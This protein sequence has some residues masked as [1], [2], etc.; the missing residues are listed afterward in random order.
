MSSDSDAFQ[1][2][3]LAHASQVRMEGDKT[4]FD[5]KAGESVSFE[6]PEIPATGDAIATQ[7]EWR[8][9]GMDAYS[10]PSFCN[11]DFRGVFLVRDMSQRSSL[12]SN[13]QDL[14]K[15]GGDIDFER[16]DL[17]VFCTGSRPT[18]GYLPSIASVRECGDAVCVQLREETPKAP[19]LQ[20]ITHPFAAVVI[21]KL[22]KPLVAVYE[23]PDAPGEIAFAELM[24][25]AEL[26]WLASVIER[27]SISLPRFVSFRRYAGLLIGGHVVTFVSLY[28]TLALAVAVAFGVSLQEKLWSSADVESVNKKDETPTAAT[29]A[30]ESESA[31]SSIESEEP[32][33]LKKRRAKATPTRK[34]PTRTRKTPAQ[35]QAAAA[36]KKVKAPKQSQ[37]EESEETLGARLRRRP[38]RRAAVEARKHFQDDRGVTR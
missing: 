3:V 27:F 30:S 12:I 29:E 2:T 7:H 13:K 22:K 1:R 9:S 15:N 18:S 26:K 17:L 16:Q 31:D 11:A 25:L 24:L 35:G 20:Q 14:V 33:R 19:A 28:L 6:V 34:T 10:V 37:H 4:E 36:A 38:S 32:Q 8:S 5:A 21:S 23:K